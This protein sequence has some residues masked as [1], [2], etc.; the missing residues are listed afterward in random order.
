MRPIEAVISDPEIYGKIIS[1]TDMNQVSEELRGVVQR[2]GLGVALL[3][4]QHHGL[5]I[6][7]IPEYPGGTAS[8]PRSGEGASVMSDRQGC[9][10]VF[11][12]VPVRQFRSD[13]AELVSRGIMNRNVNQDRLIYH[14]DGLVGNFSFQDRGSYGLTEPDIEDILIALAK[15]GA[16]R[17]ANINHP[18]QIQFKDPEARRPIKK[19]GK[20]IYVRVED[21]PLTRGVK[22]PGAHNTEQIREYIGRELRRRTACNY[23]SAQAL[24]P[25]E[26]TIHSAHA[27]QR[28]HDLGTV[29]NY[30]LGFTFAPFGNPREV[31]H[32]LAWDF[33]QIDDLL[34]NMEP[35]DYSFGDLMRLV[36]IINRDIREFCGRH[37]ASPFPISGCCNHFA[38]NSIYHQHYQFFHIPDLPLLRASG[39]T[40]LLATY[41]GISVER[42]DKW[43]SPAYLIRSP[44]PGRDA[45][46][47][48]VAE[49]VARQWC[50]L[51]EGKDMFYGNGIAL[52]NHTQNIFGTIVDDRPV[53][54][55][56]PRDRRNLHALDQATGFEKRNAGVLEMMG[57]FVIDDP[58][59]FDE[60]SRPAFARRALGDFWLARLSPDMDVIREFEATIG[61]SRD[62]H[63]RYLKMLLPDMQMP[64]PRDISAP[65]KPG[66]TQSTPKRETLLGSGTDASFNTGDLV[67]LAEGAACR[68]LMAE[69]RIAQ[70]I[71]NVC[72]LVALFI[73]GAISWHAIDRGDA[74]QGASIICAGAVSI[75]AVF[76]TGKLI[77][78]YPKNSRNVGETPTDSPD[79]RLK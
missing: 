46:V 76:V 58:G 1:M 16:L 63:A 49:H 74:T 67:L 32:F 57:Y 15:Q 78:G 43:P 14:E 9:P 77:N 45:E 68:K 24:T 59:V 50:R 36:R 60:I 29:R 10:Y 71:A 37:S 23:C 73:L 22:L 13:K 39:A 79:V 56:I 25:H 53:A 70:L 12:H 52:D 17:K 27:M 30:E 54:V 18:R 26:A 8:S 48:D 44:G 75:V 2:D 51:S 31:C 47:M 42:V 72:G 28:D 35:Q 21:R 66:V 41:S 11:V 7:H 62:R 3:V 40:R 4:A 34:I 38:G 55:F 6:G 33:P 61:I 65:S 69:R 64:L 19:S 20:E 5:E